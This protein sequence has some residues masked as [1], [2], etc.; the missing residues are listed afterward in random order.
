MKINW[1][2]ETYTIKG[3]EICRPKLKIFSGLFNST[4]YNGLTMLVQ[5]IIHIIQLRFYKY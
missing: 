1:T 4:V 3:S 5:N 2:V